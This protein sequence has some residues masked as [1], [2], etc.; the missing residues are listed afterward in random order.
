MNRRQPLVDYIQTN[1]QPT[2]GEL[3]K[4]LYTNITVPVYVPPTVDD[5]YLKEQSGIEGDYD[6]TINP[7]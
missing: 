2:S 5:N 7:K 3:M 4:L 1:K 6:I